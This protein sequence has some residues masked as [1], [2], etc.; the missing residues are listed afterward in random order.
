MSATSRGT[1]IDTAVH[2]PA[3]SRLTRRRVLWC[4]IGLC[5]ALGLVCQRIAHVRLVWINLSPSA[6]RGLY[7][8][9]WD[10]EIPVGRYIIFAVP[11]RVQALV[12]TW[13]WPDDATLLKPVAAGPGDLVCQAGHNLFINTVFA[14]RQRMTDTHGTTLPRFRGCARLTDRQ[15]FTLATG[16]PRSFDSRYFGVV[17]RAQ[18]IAVVRPLAVFERATSEGEPCAV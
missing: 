9:Q 6:P 5:L 1:A 7:L 3:H 18:I 17:S 13:G 4:A 8:S 12:S 16:S 11:R 14:A 2:A 10:Q 15:F